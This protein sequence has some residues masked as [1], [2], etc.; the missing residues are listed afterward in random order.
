MLD[1]SPNPDGF[2]FPPTRM[3]ISAVFVGGVFS[4]RVI[5][6]KD[7]LL[8]YER[9]NP[10]K[11]LHTVMYQPE[12]DNWFPNRDALVRQVRAGAPFVVLEGGP[13]NGPGHRF[14]PGNPC[15]APW[16]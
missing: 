15:K 12:Y 10:D 7:G 1:F 3:L 9:L 5:G 14:G 4:H 11:E 6:C 16:K 2:T 13:C 8:E